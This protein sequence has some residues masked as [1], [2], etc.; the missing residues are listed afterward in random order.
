MKSVRANKIG[1]RFDLWGGKAALLFHNKP[2]I[3]SGKGFNKILKYKY[4]NTIKQIQIH[5]QKYKCTN[6]HP[7]IHTHKYKYTNTNTQIQTQQYTYTQLLIIKVFI[8]Y[9]STWRRIT[10]PFSFLSWHSSVAR[11]WV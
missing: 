2:D 6:T 8:A 7:K 3:Q 9:M 11:K 4:T 10:L 5:I 1:A